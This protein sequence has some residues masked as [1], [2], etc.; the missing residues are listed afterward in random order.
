MLDELRTNTH[1]RR[2]LKKFSI[3]GEAGDDDDVEPPAEKSQT[4]GVISKK[5][6]QNLDKKSEERKSADEKSTK[7]DHS[8]KEISDKLRAS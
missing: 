5:S 7:S 8:K 3:F 1:T 6:T 2:T 4:S